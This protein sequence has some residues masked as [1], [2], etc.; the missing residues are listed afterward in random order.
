LLTALI[1]TESAISGSE[2]FRLVERWR[3]NRGWW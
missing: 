2:L 3:P 1:T